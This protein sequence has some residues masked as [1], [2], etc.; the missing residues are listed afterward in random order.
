[1]KT[2]YCELGDR[3]KEEGD[4]EAAIAAYQNAIEENPYS[5]LAYHSLGKALQQLGQIEAG[6]HCQQK[7]ILLQP[8]FSPAYF[9]LRY[10]PLPKNSP[11]IEETINLYR[12]V[13][14]LVPKFSLVYMNLGIALTKQRKI[15]EA[16]AAFQT[17][18]YLQTLASHPELSQVEWDFSKVREPDFMIIGSPRCG[19]TSLYRYLTSHPQILPAAVKEVCYFS[20][21][22]AQNL[23]WY[24]SHFPPQFATTKFMAGEA[25]PTYLNHPDA[26]QRIFTT[27]PNTKFIIIL[28]N[29][30]NRTLSHYEMWVRRGTEKRSFSAVIHSELEQLADATEADLEKGCY[31]K[32]CEYLDKSLYVYK[33]KHWMTLF[34]KEQFLILQSETFYANPATTLK[35]VFDFLN[36]P[37]YSLPEYPKYNGANYQGISESIQQQ[38]TKYFQPHNQKL[39]DYLNQ[40]FSW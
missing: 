4:L 40:E 10:A 36:L 21:H 5:P 27:F 35:Q 1:M 29:P 24:Q 20:E 6:L 28:R 17:G 19:T 30:V 37:P 39:K 18:V 22:F 25:T 2:N 8:N 12:Q 9:P 13:I 38:L 33:I 26:A 23:T 7:A 15:E 14:P 3:L 31:W 11:L 32:R 34:P 16:I